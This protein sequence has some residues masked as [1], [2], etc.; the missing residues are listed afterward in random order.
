MKMSSSLCYIAFTS[1]G[2]AVAVLVSPKS[3]L[4][5][6]GSG[7]ELDQLL[8]LAD[9]SLGASGRR[10]AKFIDEN[11]Q[12]VLAS[13]AAALGGYIGTSDATVLRT[14]QSLGFT[15]L[16]DLKQ[17]ILKSTDNAATPADP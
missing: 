3:S 15:G 7:R 4:A 9:Q 6:P 16:G 13:S 10:V 12:T 11:R 5:S 8:R 17:A 1:S 14:I 2:V